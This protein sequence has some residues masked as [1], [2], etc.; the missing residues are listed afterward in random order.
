MVV[1]YVS[2]TQGKTVAGPPALPTRGSPAV[3]PHGPPLVGSA[4]SVGRA[5]VGRRARAWDLGL[6]GEV[7]L[8]TWAL[9][10]F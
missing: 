10:W 6:A 3:G 1:T 5:K 9:P 4:A 7:M 8:A 2:V